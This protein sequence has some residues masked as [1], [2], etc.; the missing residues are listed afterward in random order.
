M[1]L[2]NVARYPEATV[3]RD[4][5]SI[6]ILFGGPYGEQKMRDRKSTRLNSS[7]ANIS[8]AAFCLK[9]QADIDIARPPPRPGFEPPP[10]PRLLPKHGRRLDASSLAPPT[11]PVLVSH[12]WV[13]QRLRPGVRW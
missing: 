3:V 8:Y 2:P 7:H 4:E 10:S 1:G 9:K 12:A 6:F 13:R 11:L 5:T